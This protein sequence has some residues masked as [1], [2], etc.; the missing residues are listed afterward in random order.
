MVGSRFYASIC[1]AGAFWLAA[2]ALSRAQEGAACRS[3]GP[4]NR[5]SDAPPLLTLAALEADASPTQAE[6]AAQVERTP[7]R[8]ARGG[9][10]PP[11]DFT[12]T[13]GIPPAPTADA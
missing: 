6:V 9:N 4:L 10:R 8:Q 2:P 5:L 11:I 12:Q 1:I 3:G 7:P 13:A